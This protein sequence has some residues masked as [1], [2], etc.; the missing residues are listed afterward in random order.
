MQAHMHFKKSELQFCLF[1]CFLLHLVCVVCLYVK[2]LILFL[3]KGRAYF[4]TSRSN[5]VTRRGRSTIKGSGI[6]PVRILT[7]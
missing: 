4:S 5:S 6:K 1:V 3:F 2:L 7:N